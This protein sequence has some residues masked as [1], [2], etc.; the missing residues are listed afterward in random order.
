MEAT[1]INF[2]NLKYM[3]RNPINQ[4]TVWQRKR[5]RLIEHLI[6]CHSY[7]YAELIPL[8]NEELSFVTYTEKM[9]NE[10]TN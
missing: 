9:I 2:P 4:A 1:I 10:A 6:R 5:I 7:E 3:T 8:S